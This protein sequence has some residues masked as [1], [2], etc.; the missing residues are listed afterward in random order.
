MKNK[1]LILFN[2]KKLLPTPH[3]ARYFII[4][5]VLIVRHKDFLFNFLFTTLFI[6]NTVNE[7]VVDHWAK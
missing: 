3:P 1:K 4:Q 2:W 7:V 5:F 6:L